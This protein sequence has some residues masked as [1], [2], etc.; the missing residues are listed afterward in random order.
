[1]L[2]RK[3][4]ELRVR[5][6]VLQ[7][8]IVTKQGKDDALKQIALLKAHEEQEQKKRLDNLKAIELDIKAGKLVDLKAIPELLAKPTPSQTTSASSVPLIESAPSASQTVTGIHRF[9]TPSGTSSIPSKEV[10][11][12]DDDD[13]DDLDLDFDGS[14][15]IAPTALDTKLFSQGSTDLKSL[16]I[17]HLH[18]I[19]KGGGK[20][21]G[22]FDNSALQALYEALH[23]PY[24]NDVAKSLA[25]HGFNNYPKTYAQ[26]D[27][28]SRKL[29]LAPRDLLFT[30]ETDASWSDTKKWDEL[31]PTKP[32]GIW[33]TLQRYHLFETLPDYATARADSS[34]S[35][36]HFAETTL[37]NKWIVEET[38]R[39]RASKPSAPAVNTATA[40]TSTTSTAPSPPIISSDDFTKLVEGATAQ[41]KKEEKEKALKKTV[42]VKKKGQTTEKKADDTHL[43][44]ESADKQQQERLTY[45]QQEAQQILEAVQL[46]ESAQ[47]IAKQKPKPTGGSCSAISKKDLDEL[48]ACYQCASPSATILARPNILPI[49][50]CLKHSFLFNDVQYPTLCCGCKTPQPITDDLFNMVWVEFGSTRMLLCPDCAVDY[51]KSDDIDGWFDKQPKDATLL[52]FQLGYKMSIGDVKRFHQLFPNL[53]IHLQ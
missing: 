30:L 16:K 25:K 34:F 20:G 1:M 32:L 41:A 51:E 5:N 23:I 45:S 14:S 21:D 48:V 46:L 26:G 13:D 24:N 31:Q 7:N 38:E 22:V 10:E 36:R 28:T 44:T 49:G 37:F 52:P 40:S 50:L 35:F 2:S 3:C 18:P 6:E 43:S 33:H 42:V 47:S 8:L 53:P 15:T 9:F 11:M 29:K 12:T 4:A 19:L 27:K 39:A 17:S